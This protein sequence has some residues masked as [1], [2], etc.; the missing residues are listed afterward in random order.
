[1]VVWSHGERE[2]EKEGGDPRAAFLGS[3]R[4]HDVD[5]GV[6]PA[7]V[8]E[9]LRARRPRRHPYPFMFNYTLRTPS[10]PSSRSC[11]FSLFL[12]R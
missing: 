5:I 12:F 2:A 11:F 10:S 6:R 7:T 9:K 4:H 8:L 1:M 3:F